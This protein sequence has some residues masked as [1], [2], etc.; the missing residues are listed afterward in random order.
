MG[1][2]EELLDGAKKCLLEWGYAHTTARDIV[3]VSGTNLASIGYHFGSKDQLLVEAMMQLMQDW[4]DRFSPPA[5]RDVQMPSRERFTGAWTRL[6]EQ[7]QADP[8]LL[9]ASFEIFAQIRRT[10]ELKTVMAEAYESIR[11][12]FAYDFLS[13]DAELQGKTLR[14]VSSLML[15]LLSGLATQYLADPERAPSVEDIVAG[16][17]FIG[18]A[19][20]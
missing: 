20:G 15:A 11:G 14:A 18:K 7:F 17:R 16:L 5:L 10:P 13:P 6:V 1:H 4:G 9:I 2:R 3:A 12:D 8:Q 19:L